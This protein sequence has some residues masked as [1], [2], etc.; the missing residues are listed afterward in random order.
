M[1]QPVYFTKSLAAAVDDG[2]AASQTP[3]GAGP[4]TLTASPIV[5][6][7]PR[8]V[9]LTF[10][11][12]ETGHSFVIA[13]YP[14]T[15]ASNTPISETIA[16]TTAG[17]VASTRMYGQ[18]TSITISAAATDAITA[19]TNGVGA[20]PWISSNYQLTDANWSIGCT[21]TGTVNYSI[22]YT[23]SDF[24]SLPFGTTEPAVPVAWTDSV[25]NAATTSKDTI[26]TGPITGW[27]LQINS[28]TGSVAVAAVQSGISG[29]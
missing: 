19:G 4:L 26:L 29:P 28:G 15:T 27:A 11:G 12:D 7:T 20:S 6:D 16:G 17:T 13:G 2:I 5:L 21:V 23:Y 3:S 18:V 14:S 25:I 8:Q 9:I 10:A 24:W 1:S 22:L